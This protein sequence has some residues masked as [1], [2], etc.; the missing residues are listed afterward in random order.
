MRIALLAARWSEKWP[1]LYLIGPAA[2]WAAAII[3][4]SHVPGSD[5]PQPEMPFIEK[6]VQLIEYT[7]LG[8]L[9]AWAIAR[10][11][12]LV[13]RTGMAVA[14]AVAAFGFGDELH[15]IFIEDRTYDMADWAVDC[16]MTAAIL[17]IEKTMN[18]CPGP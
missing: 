12:R 14:L 6:L 10:K 1:R 8:S 15:Q 4:L 3:A 17:P 16:I 7:V 2:L 9:A 18:I 11:R 13:L 5:L